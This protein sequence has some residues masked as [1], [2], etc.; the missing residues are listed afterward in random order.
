MSAEIWLP[1]PGAP[2]VLASSIGRI[3][4]E[5][6]EA[7][8]PGGGTRTYGGFPHYGC[9]DGSRFIYVRKGKTFKVGRLVCEAFHGPAP[10][11]KPVAMHLDEDSRNNNESNLRWGSQKENLN[12]PGFIAKCVKRGK[13]RMR[14]A[15]WVNGKLAGFYANDL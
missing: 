6:Y 11:D 7:P 15:M 13:A 9:W 12:A 2:G 5:P 8:M 10:K 14:F 1:V 3:M 4:V